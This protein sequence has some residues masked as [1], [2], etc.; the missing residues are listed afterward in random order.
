MW[1]SHGKLNTYVPPTRL[2]NEKQN[3]DVALASCIHS[4]NTGNIRIRGMLRIAWDASARMAIASSTFSYMYVR[5]CAR[6][7]VRMTQRER[8]R[9]R[10]RETE[11]VC[12]GVECGGTH[13]GAT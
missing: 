3:S 1:I 7:C 4:Y 5:V 11:R 9:D 10:E 13:M 12:V 8:E 2:R 6:M